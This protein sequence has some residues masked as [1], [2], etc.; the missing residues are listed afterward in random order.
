MTAE[1][2]SSRLKPLYGGVLLAPFTTFNIGGPCDYLYFA[3][4]EKSLV[5]AC[6]AALGSGIR[7]MVL[8]G[9]SN[10]LFSSAGYR[11]LIIKDDNSWIKIDGEILEAGGGTN[12]WMLAETA[13]RNSLGGLEACAGIRGNLAGAVAGNAGAYGKSVGDYI[14][15]VRFVDDSGTVREEGRD[16]CSFRYRHSVFKTIRAVILSARFRLCK[17]DAGYLMHRI[18]DDRQLRKAKH[19]EAKFCAGSFFK[20]IELG[21]GQ[22]LAAGRLLDEVKARAMSY[23]DAALSEKHSNFIVNRGRASSE[24]ITGLAASL[25]LAVLK[26]SGRELSPEVILLDEYG[27]LISL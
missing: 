20:N 13:A 5:F 23:G 27:G 7:H 1:H 12:L 3:G 10:I 19:P 4:D 14:E 25:K 11:G 6:S 17:S 9:G 22:K 16:F 24:D 26:K 2:I 8:G 18:I 21:D 15:S